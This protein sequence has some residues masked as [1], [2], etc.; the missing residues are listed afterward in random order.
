[1]SIFWPVNSARHALAFAVDEP[2]LLF[3]FEKGVSEKST[4]LS[5]EPHSES[6]ENVTFN[7]AKVFV[8]LLTNKR[9]SFGAALLNCFQFPDFFART[10]FPFS[11]FEA[12]TFFW[13]RNHIWLSF[14]PF[15]KKYSSHNVTH[16]QRG[17]VAYVY[18]K[19]QPIKRCFTT[20]S[21]ESFPS[22][23]FSV[24]K[25]LLPRLQ[26]KYPVLHKK[27]YSSKFFKFREM[28]TRFW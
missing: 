3:R 14:D 22:A 15:G 10:F 18:K 17:L 9:G 12:T 13:S 11:F 6:E 25:L 27:D 1:M 2:I 19:S 23:K 21:A 16:K 28:A 4:I 5:R 7:F 26:K 20:Q 8:L 24:K